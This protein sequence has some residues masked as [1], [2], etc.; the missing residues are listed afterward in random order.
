MLRLC[1]DFDSQSSMF[2]C[3]PCHVLAPFTVHAWS[4]GT[5]ILDLEVRCTCIW[6]GIEFRLL[7]F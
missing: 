5:V 1:V 6:N 7:E 3:L 2:F 4:L